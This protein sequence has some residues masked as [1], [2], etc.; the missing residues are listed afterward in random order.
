MHGVVLCVFIIFYLLFFPNSSYASEVVLN[1]IFANPEDEKDEFIELYNNSENEVDLSGWKVADLVKD[2]TIVDIKIPGKGFLV[3]DKSLSG[4]TLNNSDEKVSLLDSNN[5]TVDEY[6]YKVTIENKSWSRVPDGS[7]DFFSNT[8]TSKGEA[9]YSAPTPTFTTT[10]TPTKTPKPTKGPTGTKAPTST[11]VAKTT[12]EPIYE[13]SNEVL[14]QDNQ[15]KAADI[16]STPHSQMVA[17]VSNQKDEDMTVD[18]NENKS[19]PTY[20]YSITTGVGMLTL[21]CAI[22]LYR[23]FKA[24]NEEDDF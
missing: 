2:Y 24:K 23:R 16:I 17:G 22:L 8:D 12:D 9:N 4:I 19:S 21:A 3:L 7:G 14:P 11:S 20:L 1:E 13:K 6:S 10:P 18:E 5:N 15:K